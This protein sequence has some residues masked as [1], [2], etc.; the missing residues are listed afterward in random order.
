[1]V[2]NII[3]SDIESFNKI[4]LKVMDVVLDND[5]MKRLASVLISPSTGEFIMQMNIES[6]TRLKDFALNENFRKYRHLTLEDSVLLCPLKDEDKSFEEDFEFFLAIYNGNDQLVG[7]I[8]GAVD[9]VHQSA[10]ID[11]LNNKAHMMLLH[12]TMMMMCEKYAVYNRLF[13]SVNS[14][15]EI[16]SVKD[17]NMPFHMTNVANLCLKLAKKSKLNVKDTVNLYIAALMHDIGKLYLPDELLN[18]KKKYSYD[19]YEMIKSHSEKSADMAK[20]ELSNIPVLKKVPE[21]IRSHHERYDGSGYP[22]GLKEDQIPKLSRYLM[23]ADSVD[24]MLTHRHYKKQK[25]RT[26][27]IKELR[28]CSGTQFDPE[29]VPIMIDVLK[30]SRRQYDIASVVGTNYIHEVALTYFY[31]NIHH[32]VTLQGSLVMQKKKGKLMLNDAFEHDVKKIEG[33]RLCF[34]YLNDIF[35]Y[36]VSITRSAG[37]QLILENF[38]FEPLEEQFALSWRMRAPIYYHKNKR[39]NAHVVKIGGSSCVLEIAQKDKEEILLDRMKKIYIPVQL[40]V[41]SFN[42]FVEI[43]GRIMQF[44]DFGDKLIAVIKYLGVQNNRRE[45]LMR[46]LFKKQITERRII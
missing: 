6:M 18:N 20:S 29:L 22:D 26:H 46:G 9:S 40:K 38:N 12:H 19:E 28:T 15:M 37:E 36:S 13:F 27:V 23:I 31:E 41:E 35:E 14:Y 17:K 43:E 39:W 10:I 30:E 2:S 32:V 3:L 8:Y 42:E 16:L 21:I 33:A 1:M 45:Y 24:A 7:L 25:N 44:F 11:Y 34:F 5:Q 4:F